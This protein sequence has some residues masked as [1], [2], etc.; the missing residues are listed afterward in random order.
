MNLHPTEVGRPKTYKYPDYMTWDATNE[1]FVV[2][3]PL[4]KKSKTWAADKEDDA[5]EAAKLLNEWLEAKRQENALNKYLPTIQW[6]V[7]W[8][9]REKLKFIP[10]DTDTRKIAITRIDRF[11]REKGD[12]PIATVDCLALETWLVS[13]CETADVFNKWRYL[14]D[15]LWSFFVSKKLASVNEAEKIER[16]ST[17]KKLEI[18]RKKRLPLD[19]EGFEAIHAVASPY[20]QLAMDISIITLQARNEI[21]GMQHSHFRNG[22]LYVIRDKVSADSDMAFIK[23]QLTGELEE[24]QRRSRKLDDTVSPMLIHRKPER[25]RKEWR[26]GKLHWTAVRPQYLTRDFAEIR[27]MVPRF[28]E[29]PEE[30]RPTFHEIR[31]LGSRLYEAAGM[32][33]KAIQALMTHSN[34]RTTEIYLQGG[35]EALRDDDYVTVEAPMKLSEVLKTKR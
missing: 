27:D 12:S 33:K 14:L 8:W 9:K 24:F 25:T 17:S 2:R 26:E 22:F 34:K 6:G 30:Q 23:I 28:K 21:C 13:F 5:R 7:D 1:R 16:R 35:L 18:N 20:L 3:N 19:I 32:S 31:G 10:W 29:M 4:T 15:L 11:C